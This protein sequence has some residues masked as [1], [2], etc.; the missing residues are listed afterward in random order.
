MTESTRKKL[1]DALDRLI[2]GK[3]NNRDLRLKAEKGKLK[4]NDSTVE[5]EAGKSVGVLRNHKDIKKMVKAKS[6]NIR[7][8]QSNTSQTTI[9]LLE[10][11]IKKLK[12][13]R[14][15]ANKK[16]KEYYELSKSHKQSHAVQAAKHIKIVK[17][18]MEMIPETQREKAMDKIVHA[19]PDNIIKGKFT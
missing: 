15:H 14:T 10:E 18:L 17:E 11:E 4:V 7:V 9:E 13:Q 3:P 6:L 16:K 1:I 19:R 12:R 2:Q 5:K 8:E